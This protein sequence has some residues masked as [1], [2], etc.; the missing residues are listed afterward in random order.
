MKLRF[1]LLGLIFFSGCMSQ[2]TIDQQ[3][4]L[5]PQYVQENVGD[6]KYMPISWGTLMFI[7]GVTDKN[8]G[9]IWLTAWANKHALL[10]EIGHS[11]YFRV[12]NEEFT[13]EFKK[14]SGFVSI[15]SIGHY[16]EI[17]ECFVE[18]MNGRSN[19]KIDLAMEFFNGKFDLVLPKLHA[20]L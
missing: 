9:E 20:G 16:E 18:G 8:T 1:L 12:S 10:H 19:P 17:A 4:A 2:S 13:K 15:W 3:L 11:V 5:C 7:S 6:I 14:K